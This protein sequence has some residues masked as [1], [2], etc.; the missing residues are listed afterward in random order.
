MYTMSY[1]FFIIVLQHVAEATSFT[2]RYIG[3]LSAA[4]FF[5]QP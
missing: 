1:I 2:E 3:V 4:Q 5:F